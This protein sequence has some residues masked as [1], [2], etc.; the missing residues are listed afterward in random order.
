MSET[1][2]LGKIGGTDASKMILFM[3]LGLVIAILILGFHRS[4][5]A[6]PRPS[7]GYRSTVVQPSSVNDFTLSR[8]P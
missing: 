8:V 2:F 6:A 5:R 1:G 4:P 7:G 3:F